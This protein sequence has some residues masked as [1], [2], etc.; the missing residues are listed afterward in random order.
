MGIEKKKNRINKVKNKFD[1]SIIEKEESFLHE[2]LEIGFIVGIALLIAL[3]FGTYVTMTREVKGVSMQPTYNN[4]ADYNQYDS[5]VW[6]TVRITRVSVIKRGDVIVCDAPKLGKLI[7]KRVIAVGG[8]TLEFRKA[9]GGWVE[10]WLNDNKIDEPYIN[11]DGN[12]RPL[13]SLSERWQ[14]GLNEKITVKK[15][16]YFVM[17]DNRNN[18]QD[19]RFSDVGFVPKKDVDGKV[20]LY[21]PKGGTFLSALWKK[22][23]G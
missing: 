1:T 22:A 9:D 21:V 16:C 23:F 3:V 19:S 13:F 17:G 6:D 7:I 4:Y 5:Q 20:Y 10:V 15:G 12:G 18:S 11:K 2:L 8:D 14:Y